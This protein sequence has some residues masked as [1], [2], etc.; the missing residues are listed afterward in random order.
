[1]ARRFLDGDSGRQPGVPL[2]PCGRRKRHFALR[3][4]KWWRF[5]WRRPRISCR[6]RR[7]V[8]RLS[9]AQL[10]VA[11][12]CLAKVARL[13]A[14]G[15]DNFRFDHEVVG[16]PDH[17]QMFDIVA[18][19]NNELALPVE[20]EGLDGPKPRRPGPSITWQPKPASEGKAEKNGQQ[21]NGG[22]ECDRCGGKGKTLAREK[23]FNQAWH[24]VA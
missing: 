20:V 1:M 3:C 6:H 13:A 18:S 11:K 16:S 23:T 9:L 12:S 15:A 24:L 14:L 21:T 10:L 8:A 19:N 7:R 4:I 5:R 22:E 17:Q 2:Q